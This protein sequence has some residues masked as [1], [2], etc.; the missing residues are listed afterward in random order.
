MSKWLI[1]LLD[2]TQAFQCL[3]HHNK[4]HAALLFPEEH[5]SVKAGIQQG[6]HS[7]YGIYFQ[8]FL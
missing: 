7:Q 1:S 8:R 3:F 6:A 4:L 5:K 2:F